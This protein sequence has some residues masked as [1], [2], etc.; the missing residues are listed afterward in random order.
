MKDFWEDIKGL[1]VQY[2]GSRATVN[3]PKFKGMMIR[4]ENFKLELFPQDIETLKKCFE[5]AQK[6]Q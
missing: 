1:P 3:K 4:V 2:W 5:S 6:W